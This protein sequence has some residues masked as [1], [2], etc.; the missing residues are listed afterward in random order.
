LKQVL[1]IVLVVVLTVGA[2]AAGAGIYKWTTST[3]HPTPTPTLISTP[4]PEPNLV[5][6]LGG[7]IQEYVSDLDVSDM[8]VKCITHDGRYGARTFVG[9]NAIKWSYMDGK[10]TIRN[11]GGDCTGIETWEIDDA[12][13]AITYLGSSK[14]P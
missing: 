5:G 8:D 10:W 2:M 4:T 13:G 3:P 1:L 9:F 12:T 14:T 11:T 7:L 6:L